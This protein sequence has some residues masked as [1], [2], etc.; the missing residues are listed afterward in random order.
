MGIVEILRKY[1]RKVIYKENATAEDLIGYLRSHGAVIGENVSIY[2]PNKTLIDKSTPWLIKI[3]DRVRITE[4]VKILTHDYSW[5]VL[6]CYEDD[7]VQAGEILGAQ[8]P[9]E[10]GTNVFIGMNAVITRGVTIGDNV[11]IGAGSVV[12]KDCESN[13][14]YAGNPAR[15][16]MSI[17]EFYQKRKQKQFAEAREVAIHY[18]ERFGKEPPREVFSEYFMLFSKPED[19]AEVDVF[20]RQMKTSGNYDASVRHMEINKPMFPNYHAFLQACYW[21]EAKETE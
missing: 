5:S 18:K 7:E 13:T 16:I 6:K 2:A 20:Q 10:I 11:I 8:S 19:A 4:G 17:S 15:R 9:V 3:G 12:T 14:V 21:E 1:V